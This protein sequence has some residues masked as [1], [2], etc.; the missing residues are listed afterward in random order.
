[1]YI[2]QKLKMVDHGFHKE[3]KN[4]SRIKVWHWYWEKFLERQFNIMRHW[5]L[6]KWYWKF[7]L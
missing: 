6:E 5:S 3:K 4:R 2:I 1:M 7:S